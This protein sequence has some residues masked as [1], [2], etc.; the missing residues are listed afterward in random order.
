MAKRE[1]FQEFKERKLQELKD[2]N[3]LF[4]EDRL[5]PQMITVPGAWRDG[6]KETIAAKQKAWQDLLSEGEEEGWIQWTNE[7]AGSHPKPIDLQDW[8]PTRKDQRLETNEELENRLEDLQRDKEEALKEIEN[9][10]KIQ[11]EEFDKAQ[12]LIFGLK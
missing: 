7:Y 5:N 8:H 10:I 11:W 6:E 2:Q 4:D 12:D 1:T 9:Q 3:P